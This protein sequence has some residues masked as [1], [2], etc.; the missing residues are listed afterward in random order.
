MYVP[1]AEVKS[2]GFWDLVVITAV[3]EDQRCWYEVQVQE[4][5]RRR[6]LP[7]SI[8]HVIADP[9]DYKIGEY[10]NRKSPEILINSELLK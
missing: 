7:L 6:E 3:D 9:P 10:R 4:K 1:G 8:Y 2:G 5:I